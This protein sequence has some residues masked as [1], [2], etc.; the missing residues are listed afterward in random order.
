MPET[1]NKSRKRQAIAGVFLRQYNADKA[2][3]AFRSSGI[4]ERDIHVVV[5]L[6]DS[7]RDGKILV[8]VHNVV[9]PGSVIEIFDSHRADYNLDGSRNIRQDVAGLT[10]GAAM[11]ATAGGATGTFVAGPIGAVIGATAGAVVGG[12]VGA[13]VGKFAEHLK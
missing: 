8:T 4:S 6:F 9:D 5:S 12:G 11:G 1:I 10:V 3:Q 2:V 13:A 7:I